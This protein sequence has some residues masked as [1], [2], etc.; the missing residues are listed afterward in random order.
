MS[1]YNVYMPTIKH[2][3]AISWFISMVNWNIFFSFLVV[4][5]INWSDKKITIEG[6]FIYI[7]FA[8]IPQ[9]Y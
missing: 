6:A 3:M 5:Q 2:V 8:L 4:S 9:I 7:S 1:K